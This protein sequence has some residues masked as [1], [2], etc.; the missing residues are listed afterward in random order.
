MN[1]VYVVFDMDNFIIG[2][3]RTVESAKKRALEEIE[4]IWNKN[5]FS[6]SEK[7]DFISQLNDNLDVEDIVYINPE[8]LYD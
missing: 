1:V 3:Y 2:V 8:T 4:Y 6:E 5:N 7:S